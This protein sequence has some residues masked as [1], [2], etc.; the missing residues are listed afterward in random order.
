MA[1]ATTPDAKMLDEL[2]DALITRCNQFCDRHRAAMSARDLVV[3]LRAIVEKHRP[4]GQGHD[5]TLPLGKLS[6]HL[7]GIIR[8]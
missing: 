7:L 2:A 1:T 4:R 6:D 3:D 5:L 8:D